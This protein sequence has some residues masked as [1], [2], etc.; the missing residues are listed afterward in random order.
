MKNISINDNAAHWNLSGYLLI[1]SL[2]ILMMIDD[3][4]RYRIIIFSSLGILLLVSFWAI[5]SNGVKVWIT[6]EHGFAFLFI[7]YGLIS[8]AWCIDRHLTTY[9]AEWLSLYFVIYFCLSNYLLLTDN[10]NK[11][12]KQITYAGFLVSVFCVLAYR[13]PGFVNALLSGERIGRRLFGIN[14]NTLGLTC[15]TVFVISISLYYSER[16]L[17]W[18]LMG[19]IPAI[20]TLGSGSRKAFSV[21]LGGTVILFLYYSIIEGSYKV[22]AIIKFVIKISI[23][24]FGLYLIISLPAFVS[25][26]DRVDGL[27]SAY[28]DESEDE[29]LSDI[30]EDS[31]VSDEFRQKMVD[32]GIEQ[33]KETPVFG[34]GLNNAQIINKRKLHF[35]AYLHNNY[36]E[37]LVN[38][39]IIGF[40]LYYSFFC[41]L[42]LKHICILRMN[43]DPLAFLSL[44]LLFLR[45]LTEWGS[46]QYF[47]PTNVIYYSFWI[48]V[49]N[50]TDSYFNAGE[51]GGLSRVH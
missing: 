15:A 8:N 32:L 17:K 22:I 29:T 41:T 24:L 45:L 50:R 36:I 12:V 49:A 9:M 3:I 31:K 33:F 20:I 42:I 38:G 14:S 35:N 5:A 47:S 40:L 19:I 10:I 37:I 7:V 13:G 18:I 34:V 30:G 2:V 28:F 51:P 25:I 44:T 6:I 46:V 4:D 16:H 48:A 21:L 1:Y 27:I 43:N 11:F 39:G 26:H 23:V